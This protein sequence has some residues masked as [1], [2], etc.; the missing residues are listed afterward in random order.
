MLLTG[1]CGSRSWIGNPSC[2]SSAAKMF[3]WLGS[4]GSLEPPGS[5]AP[6][7][8]G[9]PCVA[10][11]AAKLSLRSN[12][13]VNLVLSKTGRPSTSASFGEARHVDLAS[14]QSQAVD[15]PLNGPDT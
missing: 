8:P 5:P 15:P 3:G 11:S 2:S 6:P 1:R 12:S 4:V 14:F 9:N 10:S 7:K 13:P